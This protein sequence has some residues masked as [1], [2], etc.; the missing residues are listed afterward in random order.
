[1]NLCIERRPQK[2]TL[3]EQGD[4]YACD[5]ADHKYSEDLASIKPAADYL[6]I[7][8]HIT[9]YFSIPSLKLPV[10]QDSAACCLVSG[11]RGRVAN[12]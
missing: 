6:R 4:V 8:K 3:A 5:K 10:P 9:Q 12:N 1:M 11:K 7:P 2:V